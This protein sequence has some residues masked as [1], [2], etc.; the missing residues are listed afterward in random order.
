MKPARPLDRRRLADR[1]RAALTRAPSPMVAIAVP[2]LSIILA[3]II[4]GWLTVA[5]APLLPPFGLLMLLGWRQLHPGVL[6]VWA[7][8]PLGLAD[9]MF[10]GQP[11]G[12]AI[13]FWSACLLALDALDFR[14]PWRSFT[15]EWLVTAGVLALY[16]L[17]SFGLAAAG[18]AMVSPLAL[19]PQ[20]ALGVAVYPL[21]G[22][23]VAWCDRMRLTPFRVFG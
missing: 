6:P 4:P 1:R 21:V 15:G 9:D 20:L 8:L 3:S 2:W 14:L 5:A 10:S 17:F 13:L 19:L 7:G 11:L 12:S 22:M 18:G 23:L 16:A